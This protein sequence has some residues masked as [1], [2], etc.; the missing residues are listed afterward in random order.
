MSASL[1]QPRVW[2]SRSRLL[3][4]AALVQEARSRTFPAARTDLGEM[5]GECAA[6]PSMW[7]SGAQFESTSIGPTTL[8]EEG[9]GHGE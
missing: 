7:R 1:S 3:L 6:R 5:R 4:E 8:L 2:A 9:M